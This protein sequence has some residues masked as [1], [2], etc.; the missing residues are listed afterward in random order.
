MQIP[1]KTFDEFNQNDYLT[2][3]EQENVGYVKSDYLRISL[4]EIGLGSCEN[5]L[6]LSQ[7]FPKA[8][9]HELDQL[10]SYITINDSQQTFEQHKKNIFFILQNLNKVVMQVT[11]FSLNYLDEL[12]KSFFYIKMLQHKLEIELKNLNQFIKQISGIPEYIVNKTNTDIKKYLSKVLFRDVFPFLFM[13]ISSQYPPI[14]Y[15][16]AN[17][18]LNRLSKIVHKNNSQSSQEIYFS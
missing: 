13:L 6:N 3:E 2:P 9:M 18:F 7:L 11:S 12:E 16:Q 17:D 1:I 10:E 5:F 15:S 8:N 4:F 14:K